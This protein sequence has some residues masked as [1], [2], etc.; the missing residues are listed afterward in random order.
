[1]L[2]NLVG[3]IVNTILDPLFIFCVFHMG[4]AGAALATITG[5]I[6]I[7]RALL[8]SICAVLN[9]AAFSFPI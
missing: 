6:S 2:S 3:A 8:S 4:M 9:A 7:V 1:M 5:Q